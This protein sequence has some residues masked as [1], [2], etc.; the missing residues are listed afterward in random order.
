MPK[1][2]ASANYNFLLVSELSFDDVIGR[3]RRSKAC[4]D[5]GFFWK[6]A[7]KKCL[8]GREEDLGLFDL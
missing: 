6:S 5:R 7:F 1:R 2:V 4:H 3:L 8:D